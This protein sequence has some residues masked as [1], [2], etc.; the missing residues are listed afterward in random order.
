VD[1]RIMRKIPM[2]EEVSEDRA[3][4]QEHEPESRNGK[5]GNEC[6]NA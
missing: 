1:I 2:L 6:R 5:K 3:C 4:Q